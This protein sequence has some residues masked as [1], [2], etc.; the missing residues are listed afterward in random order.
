[1]E[2]PFEGRTIR[3]I[4]SDEISTNEIAKALGEAIGNSD[5]K[6]MVITDEQLLNGMLGAGINPQIANGFVEMQS[7]QKSGLLYEDYYRNE[8]SLGKVKMADFA[9]E[10][11]QVYNK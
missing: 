5:L 8:P 1:M 7:A 9:K 2:K 3:Y 4:A 6:W 10:F 11:A